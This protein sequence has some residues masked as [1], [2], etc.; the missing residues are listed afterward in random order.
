MKKTFGWISVTAAALLVALAPAGA[1]NAW[2]TFD[3]VPVEYT[4]MSQMKP[5]DTKV[6]FAFDTAYK[7][8]LNVATTNAI[9]VEWDFFYGSFAGGY[10]ACAASA[11]PGTYDCPG[12]ITVKVTQPAGD[13]YVVASV[14]LVD[15]T[16]WSVWNVTM[17][18]DSDPKR[19]AAVV[20]SW[21]SVN[22]TGFNDTLTEV[23]FPKNSILLPSIAD[24]ASA[25]KAFFKQTM[26]FHGAGAFASDRNGLSQY[27]GSIFNY[28]D[29]S[30]S[31]GS[32]SSSNSESLASTGPSPF[33]SPLLAAG[34][35]VLGVVAT[36]IGSARLKAN[37][38]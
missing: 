26:M 33:G 15:R 32:G 31:N 28:K 35:I 18:P 21:T 11:T 25:K 29:A 20:V 37:N 13:P 34:L 6:T 24:Q 22:P 3:P 16:D 23:H 14:S 4:T 17:F 8:K 2:G 19:A 7:P 1:A 38:N 27:T 10:G 5:T 12:G 36:R 9:D 30:S